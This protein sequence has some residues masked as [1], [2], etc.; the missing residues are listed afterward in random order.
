MFIPTSSTYSFV[1]SRLLREVARFGGDV[2]AFVPKA[3]S[4]RLEEKFGSSGSLR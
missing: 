2:S 3:V 4:D 1:A